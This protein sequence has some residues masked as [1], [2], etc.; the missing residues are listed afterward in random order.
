MSGHFEWHSCSSF[1]KNSSPHSSPTL[2]TTLA[3]LL[4]RSAP[5]LAVVALAIEPQA[6]AQNTPGNGASSDDNLEEIVVT[7]I[8]SS[9]QNSQEIK[10]NAE[11]FVDSVTAEDIGALPDRSVTEALQRIPGVAINRFAGSNDPDHFS[12]EGS[13]VVVRGL[14]QVR[15]EL[16]GR[17]TFSANNG[18]F[19]SFADVPPELMG[20]VDV[21][22]NQSAD[23]IEGG[24]AGTV[25]LRT[26]VPFDSEGQVISMNAEASY[27]DFSEKTAPTVSALYSNRW[28]TGIGQV[29][30]LLNAVYSELKSRSDGTQISNFR[31]NDQVV[32]GKTVWFP[33]GAAIR[34][35][36]YDR[37]RTGG[38]FAAQ[39]KSNDDS[40]LATLQ[41]MRSDATTAWNEHAIEVATDVVAGAGG[42]RF[43]GTDYGFNDDDV[44]TFGTLTSNTGWRD[45]QNTAGNNR[46]P[47]VGLQSNNIARSVEQNYVT[48]DYGLNFKWTPNDAWGF[49]FDFQHVDSTVSNLDMTLWGASFE[50][51]SIDARHGVPK[52]AFLP[53]SAPDPSQCNGDPNVGCPTYFGADHDSFSDPYNNF[54]RSA[55]DHAE[56]SEGDEDAFRLDVDRKF[57]SL[58]WLT[59]LKFGGRYSERDNTTR[60]TKYNWGSLSEIWG[61]GGPVWMDDPVNGDPAVAGGDPSS[62]HTELFSFDNFMR[63]NGSV[64]AV[65]PF[66][67]GNLVSNGGYA[68]ASQFAM[69]VNSEWRTYDPANG[70]WVPVADPRRGGLNSVHLGPGG[71]YLPNEINQNNETTKALYFMAQFGNQNSGDD[72][73]SISGNV[74]VRWVRTE[75]EASG[76]IAYPLAKD[77]TEEEQCTNPKDPT[78]PLP[79]F[80]ALTPAERDAA[81]AFSSGLT[82]PDKKTNSYDNF[83]PSFNLKIG[84]TPDLLLRFGFSKALAR[85]DFGLTRDYFNLQQR[86]DSQLGWLGFQGD[87]N[88]VGNP[89]LKPTRST[90]YDGAIEWYFSKVGSLTFS[91]FYKSLK[92]VLTNG[93]SVLPFTNAGQTYDVFV[94]TPINSKEKGQLK[95]FELGY[96]QT[97]DFLPG[98]WSGFGVQANYTYIDS[99]G[100]PQSTLSNGTN[101]VGAGLVANVDTSKLPLQGLSKDNVNFTI[102]YEKGP[103]S[104]RL[105]YNWRSKFLLTVRDVIVPYAPIMNEATGQL[106]GS[107]FYNVT[108]NLKIGLQGVNLLNEVTKTSQVLSIDDGGHALTA[109]RSWF[110]NDRRLSLVARVNF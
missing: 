106:D 48:S 53:P 32:P 80:C 91:M 45:D 27:G 54:W 41:F 104:T 73:L 85:A 70:D 23:M 84:L 37:E 87:P 22:K 44:F 93:T 68:E 17:D 62:T 14:N 34:T 9:L 12:I 83:L 49:N 63:G 99:S 79:V 55:M 90:N 98:F 29:G 97:Y 58:G 46:A 109:G 95:G 59:G 74:G 66:Y 65:A 61:S 3:S 50:D 24:L 35:Q 89:Y 69:D 11:V 78:A 19:L 67:R 10:K 5:A 100:V 38:A 71:R 20:G 36:D 47:P 51:V 108:D 4:R 72:G 1:S 28:E 86:Q 8:R 18:R 40:M 21:Y 105:A 6:F 33:Q 75:L 94:T 92:D 76:N 81:R 96:Q 15:S 82:V 64:P 16:N 2:R 25:N 101:D 26:R 56:D 77:L 7:G 43:V 88:G 60:Y 102:F 13:G 31:E 57:E 52:V 107:F 39:W 103:I 110:V 30:V 42:S